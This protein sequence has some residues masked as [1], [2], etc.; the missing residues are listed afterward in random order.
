[1][2]KLDIAVMVTLKIDKLSKKFNLIALW[3]KPRE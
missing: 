3:T 2:A 1:M